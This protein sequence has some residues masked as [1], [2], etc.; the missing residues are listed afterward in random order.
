M[1]HF[2]VLV[3][4]DDYE[5]QLAPYHEFECTGLN[6]QYVQNMDKL[7]EAKEEHQKN[8]KT[9]LLR[10][11]ITGWYGSVEIGP[12]DTPDIEGAHK[13]GWVRVDAS[14]NVLEF[15]DRTNPNSRWDWYTVGGRWRGFFQAKAGSLA[16]VGAPGVFA[17]EP[18]FNADHLRKG[19]VDFDGMRAV[20]EAEAEIAYTKYEDA[21]GDLT[22]ESW[23]TI[24]A[25]HPEDIDA[26]R[27][28]YQEQPIVKALNAAGLGDPF[29]DPIEAYGCGREEFVRKAIERVAVPFAIV[30][31]GE[32]F[33]K[34]RVGWFGMSDDKFSQA[35]WNREVQKLYDGLSDDVLLTLVD[36]HV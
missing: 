1:S 28:E 31:D 12:D 20:A 19:D 26:A 2:A 32:W 34:G 22:G 18:T 24:L 21:V 17:N 4:G 35:D 10:S 23:P 25:K 33:E 8:A 36:C 14:D 6:D 13:Y 27:A 11:F 3:I 5:A 30:R 16:S 15:V 7:A 9:E 29:E